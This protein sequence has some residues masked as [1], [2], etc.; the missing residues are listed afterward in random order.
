MLK[1]ISPVS[2]EPFIERPFF[3]GFF[4]CQ[5]FNKPLFSGVS[6]IQ[7]A[8]FRYFSFYVLRCFINDLSLYN[9][10]EDVF[11]NYRKVN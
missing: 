11:G 8:V 3:R 9:V 6:S 10:L 1:K 7:M 2:M 5:F 4:Y